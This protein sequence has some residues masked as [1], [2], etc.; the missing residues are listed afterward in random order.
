MMSVPFKHSRGALLVALFAGLA[1]ATAQAQDRH[2]HDRPSFDRGREHVDTRFHHDHTYLNR[3]VVVRGLPARHYDV[4]FG[5]AHYFFAGGIWYA[6]RGGAFVVIAPPIGVY[7][8]IL[9]PF[10]TTIWFG[11]VPYYYADDVYYVYRGPVAGYEVVAPPPEAE[12]ADAP[13]PEAPPPPGAAPAPPPP[14]ANEQ[15]FI[16][17]K[18]GQSP[19]QQAK[20]R[21]ECHTWASS[22]TAFDP[23]AVNGGV[24]PS[25]TANARADYDRAMDACLEGRGYTVR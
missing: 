12:V 9:P 18:N 24:P 17:P 23:T 16:Y 14:Q 21:Y 6:P 25:Q 15:L 19:E 8:P 3:G 11:G 13:P 20:D 2:D 7:A 5:G 1:A 10:Y 4:V 22:Q